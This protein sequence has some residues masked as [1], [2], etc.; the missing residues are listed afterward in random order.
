MQNAVAT[1]AAAASSVAAAQAV[2]AYQIPH[3]DNNS[4]VRDLLLAVGAGGVAQFPQQPFVANGFANEKRSVVSNHK[5]ERAWRKC[6][7]SDFL[8][9]SLLSE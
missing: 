2:A 8:R 1:A 4:V 5:V 3:H 9:K 7:H 6:Y